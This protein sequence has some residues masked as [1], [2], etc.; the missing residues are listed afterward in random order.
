MK[1]NWSQAY[2]W[3]F[4]HYVNIL[5]WLMWA[6]STVISYVM[7]TNQKHIWY[8]IKSEVSYKNSTLGVIMILLSLEEPHIPLRLCLEG[9][10]A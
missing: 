4:L 3:I 7:E 8:W 9:H 2:M 1:A 5:P 6:S 10:P